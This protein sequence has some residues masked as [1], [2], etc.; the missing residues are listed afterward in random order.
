MFA[1]P[2]SGASMNPVRSLAPAVMSCTWTSQWLYVVAPISGALVGVLVFHFLLR[3][4][5]MTDS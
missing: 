3:H 5:G 2:I 4:D 1:G